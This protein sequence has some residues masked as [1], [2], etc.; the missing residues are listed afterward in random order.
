MHFIVSHVATKDEKNELLNTFKA[1]DEN[2]D[3]L[4]SRQELIKGY[5]LIFSG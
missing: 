4:L 3:G 2:G 5:N 1:I